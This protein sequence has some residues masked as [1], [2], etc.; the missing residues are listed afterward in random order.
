MSDPHWICT[1]VMLFSMLSA[2]TG[3]ESRKKWKESIRCMD[4]Q[5][6]KSYLE[7]KARLDCD[8][9]LGRHV[10]VQWPLEQAG[11]TMFLGKV[12]DYD[13]WEGKIKSDT[14]TGIVSLACAIAI[15]EQASRYCNCNIRF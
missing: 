6:I 15:V 14:T 4:G 11:P 1:A 7:A 12:T 2:Y 5:T 13:A 9:L 3:L 10:W 8:H